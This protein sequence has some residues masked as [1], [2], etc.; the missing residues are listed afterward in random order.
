[1]ATQDESKPL[2]FHRPQS[3]TEAFAEFGASERERRKNT[4]DSFDEPL[5]DAALDL[6]MHK[7]Q[8]LEEEGLA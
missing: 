5:F 6:V 7:L 2:S 3:A 8:R 4:G 1:M